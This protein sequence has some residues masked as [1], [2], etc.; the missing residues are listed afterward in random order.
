MASVNTYLNFPGTTEEAFNFYRSV[1]IGQRRL[2]G[3]GE[4]RRRRIV[5]D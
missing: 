3:H 1:G 4:P 2:A 5:I